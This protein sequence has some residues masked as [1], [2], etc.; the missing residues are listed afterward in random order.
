MLFYLIDL[1]FRMPAGCGE[2]NMIYSAP[3][4]Y[5]LM[6]LEAIGKATEEKRQVYHDAI[7]EGIELI[8]SLVLCGEVRRGLRTLK[9]NNLRK[10]S[11][12]GGA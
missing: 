2:Q 8:Q 9:F 7:R 10:T 12:H 1:F 5:T 4:I 6:Y 11:R 3:N